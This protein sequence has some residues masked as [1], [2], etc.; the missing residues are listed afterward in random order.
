MTQDIDKELLFAGIVAV[1]RLLGGDASFRQN[2]IGARRQI[3]LTKK[4]PIRGGP[5]ALACPLGA[6]ET[7]RFDDAH[8]SPRSY[9]TVRSYGARRMSVKSGRRNR[10]RAGDRRILV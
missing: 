9:L 8:L 3:T 7:L 6:A 5:D 1:Q 2:R 4:Q 10:D